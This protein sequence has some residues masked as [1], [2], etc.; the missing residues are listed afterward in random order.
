VNSEIR[1]RILEIVQNKLT[2]SAHNIDHVMRVY[3]LCLVISKYE[4]NVDLEILIPAALLHD[5]ARV[6]ESEANKELIFNI[7]LA[8]IYLLIFLCFMSLYFQ[9]FDTN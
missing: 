3:N 4:E 8:G 9:N 2:C 6:E 5:I 1:N 7:K